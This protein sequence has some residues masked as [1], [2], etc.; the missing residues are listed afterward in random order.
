MTRKH[1]IAV[2]AALKAEQDSI[3]E[4][5]L[6]SADKVQRIIAVEHVAERLADVFKADNPAFDEDRFYAASDTLNIAMPA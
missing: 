6:T 2:A 1:F 3:R 5:E 4:S